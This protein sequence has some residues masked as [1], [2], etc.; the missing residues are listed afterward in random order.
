MRVIEEPAGKRETQE[1]RFG[2]DV[3]PMR[4]GGQAHPGQRGYTRA[5]RPVNVD[6]LERAASLLVGAGLL[7][8]AARQ[9]S[10]RRASLAIAGGA[11]LYRGAFGYC[12]AYGALGVSTAN[13]FHSGS[14]N[15]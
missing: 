4:G 13:R 14:R 10:L 6:R 7:V 3:L 11:L 8:Y 15:V 9:L 2:R 12:P 5:D 1:R